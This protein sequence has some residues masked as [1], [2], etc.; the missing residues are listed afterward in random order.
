MKYKIAIITI[1]NTTSMKKTQKMQENNKPIR[2]VEEPWT[3]IGSY[4]EGKHL[5]KLVR[6]QIESFDDFVT[7]QIPKTIYMFNP[8][9]VR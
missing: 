9:N 2:D 6:H 4:F 5:E 1:I 8:V 7:Y 3:I